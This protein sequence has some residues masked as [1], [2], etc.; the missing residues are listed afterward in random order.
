M[1]LINGLLSLIFGVFSFG[2]RI[3]A[4]VIVGLTMTAK[5]RNGMLWALGTL[6][7]PW[8][9]FIVFFIPA[10]VPKL[11]R[12]ISKHPDFEG[13]N[14]VIASIMALAAIMA[15]TDGVVSKEE[16]NLIKEY[17]TR[18]LRVPRSELA[19]Y[20]GVFN[21]GKNHPEQYEIFGNLIRNYRRRDLQ[22]TTGYMLMHLIMH[23]GEPSQEELAMARAIYLSL[24][25]SEYEF[26]SI[27]RYFMGQRQQSYS[28]SNGGQRNYQQY[29]FGQ[30]SVNQKEKYAKV[31]GVEP[32]ADL[33]TIK[34]AYRRLAKE[35]HPD[36]MAAEGMPDDYTQYANKR[37]VEINEAYE[38]MKALYA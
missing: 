23:D 17:I 15:K 6:I 8:L 29:G 3:I 9:I 21:Y 12:E 38:Y 28:Y 11:P 4:A 10:K 34:K 16:I 24:G 26:L 35:Y 33:S 5:G 22:M 7:F 30:S 13:L 37:I 31:L 27:Q 36:K 2:L 20:E 32:D 25:L 18:Q 19:A 1:A 14:P